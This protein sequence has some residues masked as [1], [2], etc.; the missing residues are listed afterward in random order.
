MINHQEK[1]LKKIIDF[2]SFWLSWVFIATCGF[3]LVVESRGY[4]L[5]VAG[6][7]FSVWWFLLLWSTGSRGHGLLLWLAG[8]RVWD[9]GL[10]YTGLVALWHVESS[11]SR[12]QTHV[13]CIGGFLHS[14]F[15]Y[16]VSP[17]R[18]KT[19]FF[20]RKLLRTLTCSCVLW[21]SYRDW[22]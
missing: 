17:G 3:S 12:A 22:L 19:D 2:N 1:N 5:V 21:I 13:L 4:S 15:L 20:T 10:W 16:S 7:G 9:H 8:S 6:L 14:G 11:C 18:S